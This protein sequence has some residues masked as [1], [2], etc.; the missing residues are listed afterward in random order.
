MKCQSVSNMN[1]K[2]RK[3]M[4]EGMLNSQGHK[5]T[6]YC[7][8]EILLCGWMLNATVLVINKYLSAFP[9]AS[10]FRPELNTYGSC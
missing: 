4:G 5:E 9:V 2:T 10:S 7:F 8:C 1:K 6:I 3:Q